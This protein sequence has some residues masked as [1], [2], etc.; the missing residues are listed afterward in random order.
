MDMYWRLYDDALLYPRH[1]RRW[2]ETQGPVVG[3]DVDL[4][5]ID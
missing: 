5:Q 1:C 4:L 2:I 3:S